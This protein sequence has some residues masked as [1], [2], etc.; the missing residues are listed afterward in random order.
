MKNALPAAWSGKCHDFRFTSDAH[1]RNQN[2][3]GFREGSTAINGQ[4]RWA[5]W[6]EV[7]ELGRKFRIGWG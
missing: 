2:V 5:E 1:A 3:P 4:I 7:F 6:Y